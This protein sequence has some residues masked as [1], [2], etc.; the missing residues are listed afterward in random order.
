MLEAVKGSPRTLVFYETPHRIV[1]ALS[2]VV[3]VLGA[4]R[5]VVVA[6]EVT[7]IY[8]EFLRGSAGELL[9]NLSSRES[10]KGEITL[11]I[12]RW[13]TRGAAEVSGRPSVR[14]RIE[15]IMEEEKID[16]KG[17]LKRV[18][19]ERGISKSEAYREWQREK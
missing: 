12:G 8:E 9:E 11:L 6:R 4:E 10:V 1:E 5:A 13:E 18:A 16:E 15:Q 17:A 7:K 19:R 14:Q 3:E 2:D